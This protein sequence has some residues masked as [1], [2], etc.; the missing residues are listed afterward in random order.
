MEHQNQ[1]DVQRRAVLNER[2]DIGQGSR[3]QYDV[4][5]RAGSEERSPLLV[6]PHLRADTLQSMLADPGGPAHH[7]FMRAS[8]YFD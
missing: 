1:P 8:G 5:R 7:Q 4:R 6:E 3:S 2:G